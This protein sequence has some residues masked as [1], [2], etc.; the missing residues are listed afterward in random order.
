MMGGGG[1][2]TVVVTGISNNNYWCMGGMRAGRK[3]AIDPWR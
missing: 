1:S 3:V 2:L